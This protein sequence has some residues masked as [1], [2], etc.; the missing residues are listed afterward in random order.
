M[1]EALLPLEKAQGIILD[2]VSPMPV[3]SIP[4]WEAAGLP[5]AEDACSDIDISPFA[6]S[7]MDGYAVRA[8]DLAPASAEHP[9]VLEVIGHEAA[10][11]V[12][13]GIVAPGQAIR[14]MTGAPMPAGADAVVKYEVVE[15]L[16]GDGNEGS[17]VSFS[18]A[19]RP[20]RVTS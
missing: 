5:L 7:S 17:R 10:G 2:R 19:R 1:S 20:M 13:D 16:E 4:V 15:V 11:H 9:V 6:N 12:F 3:V 14:I 8:L 18:G